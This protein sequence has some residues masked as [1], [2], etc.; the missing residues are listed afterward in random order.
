VAAGAAPSAQ[1]ASRSRRYELVALA[2]LLG[3]G[4]VGLFAYLSQRSALADERRLRAD[5]V[6]TMEQRLADSESERKGLA[7]RVGSLETGLATSDEGIAPLAAKVLRSVY[8]IEVADGSGTAWVAWKDG[9][10]TYL[11]TANHV[12]EGFDRA[13]LHRGGKRWPATVVKTDDVNDLGL[14]RVDASLGPELWPLGRIKPTPKVGEELILVGSPY[15]LEGTVTSGVV[16]RVTYNRVQ[17]DAAANPGNSGGP[18][19][20]KRGRVVGILVEGGGENLNFAIPI[21]R[22]CVT[23]RHC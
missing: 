15:G 17:T 11:I 19:V 9:T 14:V 6:R 8:T 10:T 23:I 18:A 5:A 21:A 3:L 20:D 16:S 2:A 22:A 4:I 13:T 7:K 12:V 1:N